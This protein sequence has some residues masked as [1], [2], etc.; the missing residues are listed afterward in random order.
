MIDGRKQVITGV[1]PPETD[2]AMIREAWPS[3]AAFPP[4][5]ALGRKLNQAGAKLARTVILLPVGL[6]VAM[7]GWIPMGLV[8]FMKTLPLAIPLLLGP[9]VIGTIVGLIF[10]SLLSFLVGATIVGVLGVVLLIAGIEPF[11]FLAKRYTLTNRR[12][13]VRHG[14]RPYPYQE[15]TLADVDEVRIIPDANSEFFR[16]AT[17]EI[18]SKGQTI[19]RLPAVPEPAGFRHAIINASKAWVPGKA[20]E[21]IQLASAIKT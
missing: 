19:L 15:V 20:N 10:G 7:L 18:V 13:M 12:L 2:E 1:V 17:L 14:L 16:A 8:Y 6:L 5:A 4:I 21:P 3:V 9:L 11:S